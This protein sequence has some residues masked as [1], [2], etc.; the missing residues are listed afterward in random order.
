MLQPVS[1]ITGYLSHISTDTAH[2]GNT[3]ILATILLS[4]FAGAITAGAV[5]GPNPQMTGRRYG[6]ALLVKAALLGAA[7]PAGTALGLSTAM[8]LAAAECGLQNAMFSSTT[9]GS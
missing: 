4:F 7:P 9:T 5:L 2:A 3:G 6:M 1:H 8:A